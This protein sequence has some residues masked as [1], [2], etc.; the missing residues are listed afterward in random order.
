MNE[1]VDTLKFR[2]DDCEILLQN[3]LK[4]QRPVLNFGTGEVEGKL[5]N[6]NGKQEEAVKAFC[7]VDT[8][9]LTIQPYGNFIQ[10]SLPK[11]YHGYNTQPVNQEQASEAIKK[12][13]SN[14][15][16]N[17][18]KTNI[19][20]GSLS[21]V[22]VFRNNETR[23]LTTEYDPV[24]SLMNGRRRSKR[25]YETTWTYHNTNRET[26][27]YDKGALEAKDRGAKQ[28]Q[29]TNL[30][31]CE[32]RL[33]KHRVIK[34]IGLETV[35][36]LLNNYDQ[37][38]EIYLKEASNIFTVSDIQPDGQTEMFLGKDD[39]QKELIY[40]RETRGGVF[41]LS[42]AK[43]Y[44]IYKAFNLCFCDVESFI[45]AVLAVTTNESKRDL[46]AKLK[47]EFSQYTFGKYSL[48]N[49]NKDLY[50]ELYYKFAV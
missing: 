15:L 12:I 22:D 9:N 46:R 35:K 40:I 34:S 42:E 36:D 26:C 24:F 3:N 18:I 31:R 5:I 30:L 19:L 25:S 16:S 33:L 23:Y 48:P 29:P 4:L 44:L 47:R 6:I 2:L 20:A 10:V 50:D 17:G 37:V 41:G 49:R 38:K 28:P 43:T 21:R 45:L 11:V 8:F 27:F 14:L 32:Q 1:S 7:N 39:I 13:E